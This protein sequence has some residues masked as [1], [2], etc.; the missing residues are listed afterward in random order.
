MKTY[1][2]I[3]RSGNT[4]KQIVLFI[5]AVTASNARM[6]ALVQ[7]R[8]QFDSSGGGVTIISVREV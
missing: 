8:A 4:G 2:C 1:E 7:A 5:R 6:E 3:A